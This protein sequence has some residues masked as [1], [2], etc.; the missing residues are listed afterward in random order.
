MDYKVTF[1]HRLGESPAWHHVQQVP[2][3]RQNLLPIHRR[4][5][6]RR[7]VHEYLQAPPPLRPALS[8]TT[9]H[10]Q[11]G[12]DCR[13]LVCSHGRLVRVRWWRKAPDVEEGALEDI[14]EPRVGRVPVR[15][16]V[17]G[18]A[19]AVVLVVHDARRDSPPGDEEK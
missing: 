8:A 15:V 12:N 16:L 9:V 5:R 1:V 18:S 13:L 11:D 3:Q 10:G 19:A 6:D 14:R 7:V 2:R 4:G 17:I